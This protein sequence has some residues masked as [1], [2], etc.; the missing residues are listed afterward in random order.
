MKSDMTDDEFRA[1]I[2]EHGFGDHRLRNAAK[3]AHREQ[4]RIRNDEATRKRE[5]SALR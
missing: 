5:A 2:S 4:S 3:A 1:L